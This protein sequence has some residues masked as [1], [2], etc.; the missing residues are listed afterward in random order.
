MSVKAWFY[1]PTFAA[2]LDL[3]YFFPQKVLLF[4]I[5]ILL[6]CPGLSLN[7]S[8]SRFFYSLSSPSI[9]STSSLSSYSQ[10]C[11]QCPSLHQCLHPP[12]HELL[13]H[14]EEG[15]SFYTLLTHPRHLGQKKSQKKGTGFNEFSTFII[16]GFPAAIFQFLQY[17][18][19]DL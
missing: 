19:V 13:E 3:L 15:R 4:F 5:A 12:P 2:F 17:I 16:Y 14:R 8:R 9:V 10:M 11:W 18:L 1:V 7:C 6:F